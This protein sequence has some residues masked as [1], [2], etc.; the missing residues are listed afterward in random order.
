MLAAVFGA[1]LLY[2][3]GMITPAISV[4]GAVEGLQNA[5]GLPQASIVWISV[6]F[7]RVG[8]TKVGA[9]FGPI[10]TIW[11]ASL[12]ALG[13]YGIVRAPE[14]LAAIDPRHAFH[15]LS[16]GGWHTFLVL[17]SVFLCVTGA[18]SLSQ[19]DAARLVLRR[20]PCADLKLPGAGSAAAPPP[21]A[22]RR[23][24][25]QPVLHAR[26]GMGGPP[27]RGARD[28]GRFHCRPRH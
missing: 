8:T 7:Q 6:S 1:A 5:W 21:G 12:S 10:M 15:F 14:I 3:D 4:L 9:V 25:L 11:F 17:G 27:A 18:E 22:G 2:G 24:R 23:P 16:T 20:L 13:V 19:T 26:T 28:H